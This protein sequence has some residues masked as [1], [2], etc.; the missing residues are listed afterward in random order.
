MCNICNGTGG[1]VTDGGYYATFEP[2]PNLECREA[3]RQR[4]TAELDRL[5]ARLGIK[6]DLKT[7]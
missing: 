3:A 2:C 7:A 1:T 4:A 6:K 5:E